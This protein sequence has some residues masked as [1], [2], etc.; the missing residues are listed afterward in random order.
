MHEGQEQE[1]WEDPTH[2]GTHISPQCCTYSSQIC[3][4]FL[5]WEL[6]N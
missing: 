6:Q 2:G 1:M 3:T 4:I 5:V